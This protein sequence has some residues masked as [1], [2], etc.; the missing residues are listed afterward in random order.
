MVM[1]IHLE[2][3]EKYIAAL[4]RKYQP[5]TIP[6]HTLE[7]FLATIYMQCK[8]GKTDY[9]KRN[10]LRDAAVAELLF[11]TCLLEADVDIRYIQEMLGHS[12]IS[13]TEIYTHVAVYNFISLPLLK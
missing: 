3:I 12:S 11:A 6:L 9:Q 4:H 1:E 2:M 8:N 13:I 10:A 5:K 7:S